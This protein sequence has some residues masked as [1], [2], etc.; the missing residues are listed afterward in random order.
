MSRFKAKKTSLFWLYFVFGALFLLL[1]VIL[2]PFWIEISSKI[3]WSNW[4]NYALGIV[5]GILI[6]LYV[7]LVLLKKVKQ[8]SLKKVV[9][10]I[11]CVEFGLMIVFAACAI[12]KGILYDNEKFKF[13]NTCQILAII[14]WVRGVVEII[15]AY[16]HEFD[17]ETKY[18]IWYLF[19]NVLFISVGP[20]LLFVGIKYNEEV[21]LFVS[22]FI[23][24]LLLFA[25][26]FLFI[27]G[28]LSKPIKIVEVPVETENIDDSVID[29][30]L[31]E[32]SK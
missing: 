15:S 2:A 6:L 13:L 27:Y 21:D 31:I 9:R 25:G 4:F 3:P 23:S 32:E 26:A 28:A 17:N 24:G 10:I 22:Y 18:P 29:V 14:L 20:L 19:L 30:D 7:F 8:K 5:V 1:S 16:Y 11:M 12:V